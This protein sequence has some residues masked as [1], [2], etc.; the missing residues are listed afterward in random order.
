MP[1][2][3]QCRICSNQTPTTPPRPTAQV[4]TGYTVEALVAGA[5]SFQEFVSGSAVGHKHINIA[6][7]SLLNVTTL[8]LTVTSSVAP[9]N[10]AMDAFDPT[11]CAIAN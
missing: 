2:A 4:I 8:R 10:I 1:R 7:K 11:P 6:P 3:D 9:P 5:Q